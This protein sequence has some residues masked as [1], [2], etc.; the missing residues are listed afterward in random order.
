[1]QTTMSASLTVAEFMGPD[2]WFLPA[3]IMACS[4]Q[5]Q[6]EWEGCL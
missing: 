3:T 2:I 5:S 6:H 1:L 4:D